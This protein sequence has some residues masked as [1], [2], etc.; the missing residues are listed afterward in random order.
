M[1]IHSRDTLS[2]QAVL[3]TLADGY[4]NHAISTNMFLYREFCVKEHE[5]TSTSKFYVLGPDLCFLLLPILVWETLLD[6]DDHLD[7]VSWSLL[8]HSSLPG[9]A[10]QTC[11]HNYNDHSIQR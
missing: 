5:R 9:L 11:T 10:V 1:R 7:D 3:V 8:V 6:C 2:D 4:R